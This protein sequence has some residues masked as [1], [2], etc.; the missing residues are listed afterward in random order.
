MT[1][2][3]PQKCPRCTRVVCVVG[4]MC[5]NSQWVLGAKLISV[6]FYSFLCDAAACHQQQRFGVQRPIRACFLAGC[7]IL[8]IA[9]VILCSIRHHARSDRSI[10]ILPRIVRVG[11]QTFYTSQN[12]KGTPCRDTSQI[13]WNWSY[14]ST[15]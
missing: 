8:H 12:C 11:N 3:I 2:Y 13:S 1:Y 6:F 9:L 15:S 7:Q 5:V 10:S 4:D 14:V